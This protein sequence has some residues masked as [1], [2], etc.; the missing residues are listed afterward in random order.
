MIKS[1]SIGKAWL[2]AVK[3]VFS[4]GAEVF[5]DDVK[6][7][8]VCPLVLEITNFAS[9]DQI[10]STHANKEMIETLRHTFL[11]LDNSKLGWSYGKRIFDF[12]GTNQLE[13]V[14]SKLEKKPETKGA[15][16]TLIDPRVDFDSNHMPC[17]VSIDFKI[18]SG[19]LNCFC[20]FRSQDIFKKL[21]G[22][23]LALFELM[24]LVTSKVKTD[25]GSL[26]LVIASAHIYESDFQKAKEL[27]QNVKD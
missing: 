24:Q 27:I 26:T 12:Y 7:K 19:K 4:S 8:E 14:V 9:T 1:N 23:S 16:I 5:D 17:V 21:P 25:L 10:L 2:L 3:Q 20:F 13:E 18:R 15:T 11:K 6:L 22:D